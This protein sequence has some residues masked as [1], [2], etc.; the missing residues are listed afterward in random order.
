[1]PETAQ[2]IEEIGGDLMLHQSIEI[3]GVEVGGVI[4][5][6]FIFQEM[7]ISGIHWIEEVVLQVEKMVK[8]EKEEEIQIQGI[9]PMEEIIG[10][11][12]AGVGAEAGAEVMK[13]EEIDIMEDIEI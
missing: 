8:I 9:I 13:G 2:M 5:E 4:H 12:E 1:M 11:I 7:E 10:D 6:I 3:A